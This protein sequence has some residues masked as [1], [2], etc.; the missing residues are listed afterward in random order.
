MNTTTKSV[1]R[2]TIALALPKSVP[3][4]I[5]YAQGIVTRMTGNPSFPS[6]VPTL[7][8]VTAALADLQTAETAALARTKGAVTARNEKRT[9]L[10]AALQQLRAHVQAIADADPTQ[11]SSIIESA[12]V[13]VR[14]TPTHTARAFAAKPGPVSGVAKVTAAAASRR[15]SYEWQYSA[16]GGKTWVTAP[17]TLQARTTIAGLTAGSTVQFRYRAVTKTGEGDWSQPASLMVL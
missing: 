2:P 17:A 3:A 6:P 5:S 11:A 7:A 9:V 14:K 10:V 4:L 1:R 15:A 8:A 12:G 16:D 13:A